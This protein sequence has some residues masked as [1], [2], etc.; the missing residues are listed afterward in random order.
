MKDEI[1]APAKEEKTI[2]CT[3]CRSE[4]TDAE[5][6]GHSACPR[7]GSRGVPMAISQDV[8]IRIN[9]HELRILVMWAERWAEHMAKDP[10]ALPDVTACVPAIARAIAA[11]HPAMPPLTFLGEM[12]KVQ[13]TFPDAEVTDAEGRVI[14]PRKK[15]H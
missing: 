2:R 12:L 14:L 13:E 5:V 15:V 10:T 4:F 11:Q 6:E 9:W 1:I 7:C 8:S 3:R